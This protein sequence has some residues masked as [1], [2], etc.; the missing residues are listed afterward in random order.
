[1][2]FETGDEVAEHVTC[3]PGI[4]S[5]RTGS[6]A[7]L[8][9]ELICSTDSGGFVHSVLMLTSSAVDASFYSPCLLPVP[10]PS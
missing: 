2:A 9:R 6:H 1:M 7:A 4:E 3:I 5:E 8:A 10:T